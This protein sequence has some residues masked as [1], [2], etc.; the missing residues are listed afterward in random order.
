M[1]STNPT[2]LEKNRG[3]RSAL[4]RGVGLVAGTLALAGLL[5][6]CGRSHHARDR[7]ELS[8]EKVEQRLSKVFHRAL[9]RVD[10]TPEQQS[11]VDA[12]VKRLA[13]EVVELRK[14]R[15]ALR[16]RLMTALGA[17]KVSRDQ[18]LGIRSSGLAL[19]QRVI[20]RGIDVILELSDT[21]TPDQRKKLVEAW[22]KRS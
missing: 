17:E 11:R 18:L 3:R 5:A 1:V 21:L 22:K 9:S 20:D 14:E 8:P 10:A 6:A 7:A 4:L 12:M 13:P 2:D 15:R 19:A 16:D